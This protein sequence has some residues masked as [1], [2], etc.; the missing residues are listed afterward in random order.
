[1]SDLENIFS[2]EPFERLCQKTKNAK[3]LAKA[4]AIDNVQ[5]LNSSLQEG[6]SCSFETDKSAI[7]HSRNWYQAGNVYNAY[8]SFQKNLKELFDLLMA[9]EEAAPK[10]L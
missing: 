6:R 3:L 2:F 9:D 7:S 1:M 10:T 5:E 8:L 4:I